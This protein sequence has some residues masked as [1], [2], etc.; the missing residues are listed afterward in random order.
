MI[1]TE[2]GIAYFVANSYEEGSSGPI[3]WYFHALTLEHGEEVPGFPVKI[4]GAATN[5]PEAKF[6]APQQLQRPAL[7]LMNGVVYAAFGSHCDNDPYYCW[8]F[9]Y[10]AAIVAPPVCRATK[11]G[12][13]WMAS[14]RSES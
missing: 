11:R 3:A 5:L 9:A 10:D 8:V 4:S 2:H 7:L 1:D 12:Y 13:Q 14:C 6:E